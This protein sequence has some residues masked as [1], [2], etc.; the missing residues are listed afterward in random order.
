MGGH[1]AAAGKKQHEKRDLVGWTLV[2]SAVIHVSIWSAIVFFEAA[3]PVVE[4]ISLEL[5]EPPSEIAQEEKPQ[6]QKP[7][8]ERV[9]KII[10]PEE[11]QVVDQ[12]DKQL[13]D[14][15]DQKTR[16]LGKHN[17][18]V[19]RQQIAK[20]LGEFKNV[21]EK[22]GEAAPEMKVA[23]AD[24]PIDFKPK[25]DLT[26]TIQ[27]RDEREKAVE[28]ASE[29]T[30]P[31]VNLE[32]RK[33]AQN[34]PTKK[35]PDVGRGAGGEQ[36]QTLDYIK[37]LEPGLETALSTK[38]FVYHGFFSRIRRQLEQHWGPGVKRK[39]DEMQRKGRMPASTD[40]RV[41]KCLVTLDKRGNIMKVQ[42]I[43]DSG[44]RELDEAAVDAFRSAA[45]FPN[46]PD[47]MVDDDGTIKIRWDFVLEA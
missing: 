11:Q 28:D 17:Q 20:N 15:V 2:A 44:L 7:L 30:I 36:S 37:E 13:N 24:Q 45:P 35:K 4:N 38:E 5:I 3:K 9:K 33:P 40:D 10:P 47:G 18:K 43:G 12:D 21:G 6:E 29:I 1:L 14:E 27:E 22:K 8:V 23:K 46:P 34:Q 26:R 41:T 39:I 42:V 25:F 31:T 16:F 32:A 19:V